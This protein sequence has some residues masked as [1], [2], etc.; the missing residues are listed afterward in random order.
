MSARLL[1]VLPRALLVLAAACAL[2][3]AASAQTASDLSEAQLTSSAR[4]LAGVETD[5]AR[6]ARIAALPEWQA[7]RAELVPKWARLERERLHV[8]ESWRDRYLG[9]DRVTCRTLL[10]PFSGP[11]FLNAYLLFPRCDTY[12]MFGL[13][14][15]GAVPA[16]ETMSSEE[17]GL[18]L[19]DMRHA[20]ANF[21]ARNYFITSHMATQLRTPHLKGVLPLVLA[22]MGLLNLHVAAVEPFDF[23]PGAEAARSAGR[24][25][26]GTKIT[27]SDP[28]TGKRQTLYYLSLD[29]S[30]RALAANPE[31]LPFL[32]GFGP[33][34]TFLKSASYLLHGKEFAGTRRVLLDATE[35][36]V[37]DDTGIPYRFLRQS[38][39]QIRLFGHY[40]RPIRDFNY[41]YQEDLDAAYLTSSTVEA[42]P[43]P[44][45]YHWKDGRS[46]LLLAR[47]AANRL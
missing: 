19:G 12:V 15:P 46:G 47:R 44:F 18:L 4:L 5:Y 24:R 27:F 40:A 41:G 17:A 36:L 8:I 20:L 2:C 32:G 25:A 42:L 6:H 30:D 29:A 33:S 35:L 21:V 3:G 23:G 31:F 37:E 22:S 7:H 16:F 9:A 14:A 26:R 34:V 11:D 45:G 39:F 28:Q 38:G 13:E 10:Y 43:F 1:T